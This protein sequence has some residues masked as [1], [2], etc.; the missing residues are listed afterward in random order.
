MNVIMPNGIWLKTSVSCDLLDCGYE[1]CMV[2]EL[3]LRE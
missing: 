1:F 2:A 3:R